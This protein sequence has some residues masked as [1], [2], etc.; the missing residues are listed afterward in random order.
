MRVHAWNQ[1]QLQLQL[2]NT[3]TNSAPTHVAALVD[4]FTPTNIPAANDDAWSNIS[5]RILGLSNHMNNNNRFGGEP[6][7]DSVGEVKYKPAHELLEDARANN[8]FAIASLFVRLLNCGTQLHV[9]CCCVDNYMVPIY[10]W[11]LPL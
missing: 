3:L 6:V 10:L 4:S 7:D 1:L 2:T 9:Q 11:T 8:P 5:C